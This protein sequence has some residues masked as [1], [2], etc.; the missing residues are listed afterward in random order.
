MERNLVIVGVIVGVFVVAGTVTWLLERVPPI[1]GQAKGS[2]P[3][4]LLAVFLVS[5]MSR[6]ISGQQIHVD[7]GYSIM[8]VTTVAEAGEAKA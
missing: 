6:G 2:R 5:D 7:S 1:P 4:I 3:G 8:G